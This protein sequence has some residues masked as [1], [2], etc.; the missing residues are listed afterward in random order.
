MYVNH[1]KRVA[2][3]L[4][5]VEDGAMVKLLEQTG[6][7]KVIYGPTGAGDWE[8]V[9]MDASEFFATFREA[10]REEIDAAEAPPA[11]RKR[12]TIDQGKEHAKT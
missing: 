8:P 11:T 5:P 2:G 4:V 6:D 1:M 12:E 10:T 7:H 9:T 3:E